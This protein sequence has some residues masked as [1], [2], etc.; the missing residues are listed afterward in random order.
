[1]KNNNFLNIFFV[2]GFLIS[3]LF[4]FSL[5]EATDV[6]LTTKKND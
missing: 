5:F 2:F 6:Y 4:S 1:M 3:F